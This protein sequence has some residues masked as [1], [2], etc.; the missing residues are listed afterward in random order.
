MTSSP[1]GKRSAAAPRAGEGKAPGGQGS[2]V[3]RARRAEIR[4]E[5][6]PRRRRR[7]GPGTRPVRRAQPRH[8]AAGL[9]RPGS[10]ERIRA[11]ARAVHGR[12]VPV[13][14]QVRLLHGRP[15]RGAGP[16]DLLGRIVFA[17]HPHQSLFAVPLEA[18]V[19]VPDGVPAARAVL[20]ANMETALNAVWDAAPGPADRIA[21]VGGG[22]LGA[23]VARLCAAHAG[24]RGDPGR[25]RS[26]ARRARPQRS[27]CASPRPTRRPAIATSSSTPAP[28]RPGSRP[29]CAA[30]ARGDDA[31][32]CAGTARGTSRCRSASA[33]TAAGCGS[34]RARSGRS[35]PRIVRAGTIAAVCAAALALLT[36]PVL[37]A[38][39]APAIA[40]ADLPARLAD[41]LAPAERRIRASSSVYPDTPS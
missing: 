10:G 8:R 2:L 23:L 9:L 17:L 33:S 5:S 12:R 27:A 1:M 16:R 25:H 6:V 14:R 19:P 34:S 30:P 21:V 28:A 36:D 41:I 15:G 38:L 31:S 37:D 29:R 32:S 4:D 35:R 26:G 40:F 13:S 18:V 39:L 22:V 7:R 24:H 3:C 11:H 20:A